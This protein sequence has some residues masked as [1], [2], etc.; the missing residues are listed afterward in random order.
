MADENPSNGAAPDALSDEAPDCT[1]IVYEDGSE[2]LAPARVGDV[3]AFET[4]KGRPPSTSSAADVLWL[5]HR[6]LGKPGASFQEWA[7]TVRR[8]DSDPDHV[9]QAKQRGVPIGADRP[10]TEVPTGVA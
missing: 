7:D 2:R 1:L 5:V 3:V 4:E 9:E 10:P 8:L 6:A